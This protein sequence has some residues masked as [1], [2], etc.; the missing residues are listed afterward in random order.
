VPNTDALA[1]TV[2]CDAEGYVV[3]DADLATSAAFVLAVGDIRAGGS[4]VRG[5]AAAVDDGVRA[6]AVAATLCD[7]Q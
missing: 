2:D 6:A 4:A 3:T 5:V 7:R 1:D